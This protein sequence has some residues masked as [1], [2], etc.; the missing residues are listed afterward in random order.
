MQRRCAIISS[1]G[2]DPNKSVMQRF[3]KDM[4]KAGI[5]PQMVILFGSRARGD[6]LK[7]SDYDVIV[8]S[9][10]FKG[11]SFPRRL[12]EIE[13]SWTGA[14]PIEPLAYTPEEFEGMQKKSYVVAAAIKEGTSY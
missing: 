1:K 13:E 8:V 4:V 2:M 12:M 11:V 6:S 7:N 14:E 9:D 3:K 10:K 5:A